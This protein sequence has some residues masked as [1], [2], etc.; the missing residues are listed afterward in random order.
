MLYSEFTASDVR[1]I[2]HEMFPLRRLVLS[3]FTFFNQVGVSCPLGETFKR[4][5]RCYRLLDI[6]PIACILELKERGIPF[7]NINSVPGLLQKNACDIFNLGLG[8]RLAG[9]GD[10][11]NLQL[12]GETL[13]SLV[14]DRF[15]SDTKNQLIF[16]SLD[17][18]EMG[19]RILE[20]AERLYGVEPQRA[21]A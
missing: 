17:V 9:V 4:K 12:K 2:L 11:V 16:W 5:R 13:D 10:M 18:G 19:Q 21:V 1:K 20:V 7:K 15:L 14:L 3:Q 6:L 8:S